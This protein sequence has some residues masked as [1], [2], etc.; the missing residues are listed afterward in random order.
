[1][2]RTLAPL[3]GRAHPRVV[4]ATVFAGKALCAL[5]AESR[6]RRQAPRP[7][8]SSPRPADQGLA[9]RASRLRLLAPAAAASPASAA[10]AAVAA[11]AAGARLAARAR[12]VARGGHALGRV[13]QGRLSGAPAHLLD[14]HQRLLAHEGRRTEH[15]YDVAVQLRDRVVLV[16]HVRLLDVHEH[17][18]ALAERERA[19]LDLFGSALE[20]HLEV[21]DRQRLGALEVEV[22]TGLLLDLVNR[23]LDAV[24]AHQDRRHLRVQPYQESGRLRLLGGEVT[25]PAVPL[26]GDSLL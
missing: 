6:R 15:R 7:R 11:L 2:G 3:R 25:E 9:R 22:L 21:V 20:H 17:L 24:T 26:D 14:P 10:A 1:M 12:G 16:V 8:R 23:S 19:L 5:N 18:L 4:T 13:D